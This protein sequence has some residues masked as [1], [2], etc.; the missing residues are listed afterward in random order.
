MKEQQ[1]YIIRSSNNI[2]LQEKVFI[3]P[4]DNSFT[5]ET[6]NPLAEKEKKDKE[7]ENKNYPYIIRVGKSVDF[8]EEGRNLENL[9]NNLKGKIRFVICIIMENDSS[10]NSDKL[11]RTLD[12]IK[13]NFTFLKEIHLEVKNILICIFFKEIKSKEIFNK[14]DYE[15]MKDINSYILVKKK[16]NFEEN[17]NRSIKIHCISK[18]DYFSEIEIFK[19]FYCLIIKQLKI[20]EGIIFTS[21]I[22]AGVEINFYSLKTLVLL[23]FNS[24]E[25]HNIIVPL[26]D[27]CN[28]DNIIYKIKKYERIHFNIYNL[29]FYCMTQSIP[30]LSYFNVMTIDDKLFQD[31]NIYYRYAYN[32][33]SVDFHDYNLSLFLS[34]NGHSIIYYNEN[35]MADIYLID[36]YNDLPI[37][38]YK[39]N[40]IK[41]YSGYYGNFFELLSVFIDCNNF[42]ILKK[43]FLII[44]I[45]GYIV[46]FIFPSLSSIIIY[47]IFYEAF[48]IIDSCPAIFCT[49]LY[50][51][52]FIC[53]GA[54]SMISSI[55]KKLLL[56][57]LIFYIFMEVYYVFI[58]ICAIIA[59]NNIRVN[60]N[61]SDPYKF[62]SLAI[63]FIIIL[64]F[65]PSIIPLI[66]KNKLIIENIIQALL[67]FSLGASQSTST[68]MLPKILNSCEACGGENIKERKGIIILLYFLFNLLIGCFSFYNYTRKK[69]VETVMI[70]GICFLVYNFFKMSAIVI[71]LIIN[72]NKL[73]CKPNA[74]QE[75]K[76][77]FQRYDNM[78]LSSVT[79]ASE[80]NKGESVNITGLGSINPSINAFGNLAN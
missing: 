31:L 5:K 70:L 69:R 47:T 34:R 17:S 62:N 49:L 65:I 63:S 15:S 21:V 4:S 8:K 7:K 1:K 12:S 3:L 67:Y 10:Y 9:Y 23:S 57:N 72:S 6:I 25:S 11:K 38:D 28:N 66:I 76:K 51:F 26:I 64:T 48:D 14:E 46:D 80:F 78:K 71:N 42:N 30:I 41:R 32:N 37:D 77:E 58:L 22:T 52:L 74:V 50:L 45:I 27:D 43:I 19:C 13:N 2:N 24:Q 16:F 53:S 75:I 68:Y 29:N 20:K 40:W 61:Y 36:Y 73:I 35:S 55:S 33:C 54:C 56:T 44:Q 59:T 18:I 60:N 79:M 39:D